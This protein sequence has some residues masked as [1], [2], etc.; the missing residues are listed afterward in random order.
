[1]K[2]LTLITAA[3]G[4]FVSQAAAQETLKNKFLDNLANA[5]VVA[6][7]CKDWKMNPPMV[8]PV[9]EFFHIKTQDIS[10]G[11]PSWPEFQKNIL[12][13][14]ENSRTL[15][16][17]EMCVAAAAMFGSNGVVARNLMIRGRE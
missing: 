14:Q 15:G 11:G 13:A 12:A 16:D 7:R 8:E 9:M 2:K 3:L 4:A 17:E 6:A 10:P 1:M 5:F